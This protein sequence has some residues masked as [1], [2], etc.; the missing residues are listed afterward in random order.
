MK[1]LIVIALASLTN[2]GCILGFGI[3]IVLRPDFPDT[4][5]QG[6]GCIQLKTVSTDAVLAGQDLMIASYTNVLAST[7]IDL[8]T[9]Q[10]ENLE[11]GIQVYVSGFL[12]AKTVTAA[13]VVY[14]NTMKTLEK[15]TLGFKDYGIFEINEC[16]LRIRLPINA[17][18]SDIIPIKPNLKKDTK[19]KDTVVSEL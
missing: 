6:T 5:W 19:V 17:E 8:D 10:V 2:L 3:W 1:S 18:A 11:N 13:R 14:S 16:G 7:D 12:K 9:I 4:L 15:E